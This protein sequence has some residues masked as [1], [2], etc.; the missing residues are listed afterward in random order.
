[1]TDFYAG[2]EAGGTKFNCI[3]ASGP[4]NILSEGR[5]PTTTPAETIGAVIRFFSDE[6][7]RLGIRYRALGVA[8]FGPVD[9]D[10]NSSTYGYITSTPKPHWGFADLLGPLQNALQ[11]ATEMRVT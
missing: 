10:P 7:V 5:F 6:A 11:V 4:E 8:T 1:M 9:L 3:I 2:L